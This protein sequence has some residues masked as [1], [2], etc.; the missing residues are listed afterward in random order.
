MELEQWIETAIWAECR[1]HARPMPEIRYSSRRASTRTVLEPYEYGIYANAAGERFRAVKVKSVAAPHQSSGHCTAYEI[2]LSLGT[3]RV[4]AKAT[5]LHE[6]AH[7]LTP[8]HHH[9]TTFYRKLA[10]LM[11]KYL[12]REQTLRAWEREKRYKARAAS[13]VQAEML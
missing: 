5:A 8:R 7:W 6:L 1:S 11:G 2:R 4:D 9:D 3:D 13:Q 10:E 12:T